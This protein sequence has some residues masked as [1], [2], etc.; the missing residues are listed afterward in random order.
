MTP[1]ARAEPSSTTISTGASPPPEPELP[2]DSGF[3][4]AKQRLVSITGRNK[5]VPL[6]TGASIPLKELAAKETGA[7]N[8]AVAAGTK[9]MSKGLAAPL[10]SFQARMQG[11]GSSTPTVAE[12]M[13]GNVL[14]AKGAKGPAG[15][16]LPKP[17]LDAAGKAAVATLK[18]ASAKELAVTAQGAFFGLSHEQ[19][20][21]VWSALPKDTKAALRK[22]MDKDPNLGAVAL[23]MVGAMSTAELNE[24]K[25]AVRAGKGAPGVVALAVGVELAARTKDWAPNN[26]D[27][28]DHLRES[29]TN[30]SITWTEGRGQGRTDMKTGSI[31]LDPD[32]A[33]SPEALAAALAH[34]GTHS[35]H[36]RDGTIS[37]I[38]REETSGNLASTQ[39]WKELGDPKDKALSENR[40][41]TLNDYVQQYDAFK[42]DGV[43]ARAATEYAKEAAATWEKNPTAKGEAKKVRELVNELASDSGAQKALTV[44][45]AKELLTAA[46]IVAANQDN[47]LITSLGTAF[48]NA[49]ADVKKW[50]RENAKKTLG[51]VGMQLLEQGMGS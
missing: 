25:A 4:D 6:P 50:V 29:I 45:Y 21:A 41:D 24:A 43:K 26:K 3:A 10:A 5:T 37:G 27:V 20:V 42:E 22:T 49:P 33:K 14:E 19:R 11:T 16:E 47:A 51:D 17:S 18:K 48:K 2:R 15:A 1:V 30:Q 7:L 35:R 9:T 28:V 34:E 32:L 31:A 46:N 39:V 13:R 23:G 38:Y 12:L 8:T 40:R 44:D 36:V